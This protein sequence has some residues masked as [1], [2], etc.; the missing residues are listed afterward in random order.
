M[1]TIQYA[2]QEG[3]KEERQRVTHSRHSETS[4]RKEEACG[5]GGRGRESGGDRRGEEKGV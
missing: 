1:L 2:L 3:A 4:Q 5:G